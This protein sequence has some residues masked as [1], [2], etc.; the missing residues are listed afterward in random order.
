L[1]KAVTIKIYKIMV[2]PVVEC[3]RE[4]LATVEMDMRRLGAWERRILR[5]IHVTV[6]G[7]GIWRKISNQ[8]LKELYKDLD[9]VADIKKKRVEGIGHVVRM[10]HGRT[11]K[12]I[13]ESKPEGSRRTGRPRLRWLEDVQKD[14]REMEVNRWRQQAVDREEWASVIREA[15]AVRGP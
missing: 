7:Q 8:E 11:V 10:D 13:F 1:S 4:I 12:K 9:I 14:L 6:V 15:K 2:K 5:R 3:G